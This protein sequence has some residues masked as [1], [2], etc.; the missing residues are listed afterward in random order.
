MRD[1]TDDTAYGFGR[2]VFGQVTCPIPGCDA[3]LNVD[4]SM[5]IP[6]TPYDGNEDN[7]A[8]AEDAVSDVWEVT[9]DDG[10]TVDRCEQDTNM[11][12]FSLEWLLV[13]GHGQP[14]LCAWCGQPFRIYEKHRVT[15]DY[16][17]HFHE[18]ECWD[19]RGGEGA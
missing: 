15:E 8:P 11:D 1:A 6:L 2:D 17:D 14:T 18:G 9:C 7:T 16:P 12:P 3:P 19:N 10:H 5:R 13:T 4:R